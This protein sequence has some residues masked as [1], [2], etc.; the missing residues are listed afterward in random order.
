MS[1]S[2]STLHFFSSTKDGR[3]KL[4]GHEKERKKNDIKSDHEK[5]LF[6]QKFSIG[7]LN[8]SQERDHFT[9]V[10]QNVLSSIPLYVKVH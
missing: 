5:I 8:K 4:R 1:L 10:F 7:T 2:E 6:L 3:E 9:P